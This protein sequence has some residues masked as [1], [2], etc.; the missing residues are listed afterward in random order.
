LQFLF[1]LTV[2]VSYS[3]LA[4]DYTYTDAKITGVGV[5][6][7]ESRI[8]FTIDATPGNVWI[9]DEYAG[10]ELNRLV[11]IILFAYAS[12]KSIAF[13]RT[14]DDPEQS[15]YLKVTYF[16]VGAMTHDS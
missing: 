12:D 10:E 9:T 5:A 15:S 14:H 1:F 4:A 11:S 8:R 16:E 3:A 13:I 7:G 6:P 2:F